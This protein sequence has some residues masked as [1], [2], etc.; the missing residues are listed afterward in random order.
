MSD[1]KYRNPILGEVI[2]VAIG[3]L[4]CAGLMLAV[5]AL[6]G[7]F[8]VSVL[9]GGAVGT[10]LAVGNF[11]FLAVSLSGI[12]DETDAARLRLRAQ[13]SYVI[14]MASVFALAF[15]AIRFGGCDLIATVLPLFFY[16]P[17][18]MAE[19]FILRGREE[20]AKS[21]ESESDGYES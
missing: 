11:F 14:R 10:V 2:R 20:R 6:I 3:Q 1:K 15:V 5:Y 21:Q 8:S 19:Q 17:I 9:T 7:R 18:L 16:R 13:G 12:S 4:I